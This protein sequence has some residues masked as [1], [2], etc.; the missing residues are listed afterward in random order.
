MILISCS[1][2]WCHHGARHFSDSPSISMNACRQV[3]PPHMVIFK[4][5]IFCCQWMLSCCWI[6]SAGGGGS[7]GGGGSIFQV[8]VEVESKC[9]WRAGERLSAR[10]QSE[11]GV[12]GLW[13][14]N[15]THPRETNWP[16]SRIIQRGIAASGTEG[17]TKAQV[18]HGRVGTALKSLPSNHKAAAVCSRCPTAAHSKDSWYG[19]VAASGRGWQMVKVCRRHLSLTLFD[20]FAQA[21]SQKLN[22]IKMNWRPCWKKAKC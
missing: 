4:V 1:G 13:P 22:L 16:L 14:T 9:R 7:G 5:E 12:L 6:P 3:D 8:E 21:Q 15:C 11:A 10:N 18:N 20:P 19:S 17:S 2:L